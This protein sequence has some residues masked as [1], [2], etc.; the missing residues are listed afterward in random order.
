MEDP[1]TEFITCMRGIVAAPSAEEQRA[2]IL[3]YFHPEAG[4]QHNLATV[5]RGPGGREKI[6][7]IF[8]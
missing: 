4:L 6:M 3:K 7:G 5:N 2:T 8:A 1:T